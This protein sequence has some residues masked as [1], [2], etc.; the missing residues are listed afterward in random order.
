[1]QTLQPLL[2]VPSETAGAC[3]QVLP[4]AEEVQVRVV[5][6]SI[7]TQGSCPA[8]CKTQALHALRAVQG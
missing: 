6:I 7:P 2:Q 8:A 3:A 5:R 1:V 4:Q